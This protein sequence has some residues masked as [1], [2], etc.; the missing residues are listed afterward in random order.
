MRLIHHTKSYTLTGDQKVTVQLRDN[1]IS[2]INNKKVDVAIESLNQDEYLVK[3]GDS[4][5]VGEV[6]NLKQNEVT[7]VI[8]GNTYAFTIET[9]IAAKRRA[10][11]SKNETV[12]VQ[13]ITAPLPGEIVAVLVGE[14]QEVHKG[15]PV[16]ILE[17][18]KMQNEIVAPVTGKIKSV[19]TK[20]EE[21]VMKD[22]LLF[23]IEPE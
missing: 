7:V 22:Q 14:G 20:A 15:E 10:R 12:K 3:C 4:K 16:M 21:T 9:E 17:A 23:V 11:L 6:V 5:H 18:M 2:K 8:N 13:K 19:H 1:E